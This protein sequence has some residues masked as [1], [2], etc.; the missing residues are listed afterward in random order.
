LRNHDFT[1]LVNN[2]DIDKNKIANT[3]PQIKESIKSNNVLSVRKGTIAS[4]DNQATA[5]LVKNS[6]NDFLWPIDN[7]FT[8]NNHNISRNSVKFVK[9]ASIKY[10]GEEQVYDIEVENTHNNKKSKI[11]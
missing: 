10:A 8:E 5:P 7:F 3:V 11:L 2:K 1:P 9:I 4:V 6:A